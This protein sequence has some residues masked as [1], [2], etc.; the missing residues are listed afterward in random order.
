MGPLRTGKQI[1]LYFR[2]L[3]VASSPH[4]GGQDLR[5]KTFSPLIYPMENSIMLVSVD[6]TESPR[7]VSVARGTEGVKR[8]EF[9]VEILFFHGKRAKKED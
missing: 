3:W 8:G 1:I 2:L 5:D 6:K 4:K 7:G 9:R